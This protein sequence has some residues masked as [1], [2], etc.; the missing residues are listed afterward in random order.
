MTGQLLITSFWRSARERT[1]KELS[2][3]GA[4]ATYHLVYFAT[5]GRLAIEIESRARGSSGASPDP[6][7]AG[8]RNP[9]RRWSA[10]RFRD[11]PAQATGETATLY[12][13]NSV[14]VLL[15]L[16]VHGLGIESSRVARDIALRLF[17]AQ[18]FGEH[19]CSVFGP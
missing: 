7:P 12:Q 19:A 16:W 13:H 11:C 6:D 3:S 2:D 5:H 4:L 1:V 14:Q 15:L 8:R 10:D 17:A 18:L 9:G